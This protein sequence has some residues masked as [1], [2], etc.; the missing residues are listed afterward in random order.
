MPSK[1]KFELLAFKQCILQ[2]IKNVN[3]LNNHIKIK[4]TNDNNSLNIY[5]SNDFKRIRHL[6]QINKDKE[7]YHE[8]SH[9]L[10]PS[11]I[12]STSNSKFYINNSY[13]LKFITK[14]KIFIINFIKVT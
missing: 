14:N 7:Y 2:F 8:I 11:K 10:I 5:K 9:N 12:N 1:V 3:Q 4:A 6:Y 13:L